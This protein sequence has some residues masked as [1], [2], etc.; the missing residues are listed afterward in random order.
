MKIY[1]IEKLTLV[2][3]DAHCSC[4]LF[5]G[6]CNFC[7]PFCQNSAL[8][9]DQLPDPIDENE[10]E[11]YLKARTN[12]LYGVVISGGEPTINKGLP[13]YIRHIKS[14]YGYKI[15]LD[16][17]GSNP[18]M[19]KQLV[20]EGLVDYVAMDI[21]NSLDDY[22]LAIGIE[23]YDTTK[24]KESID[25]LK[26]GHVDYEFRT[27]LVYELHSKKNIEE[28]AELLNG[29]KRYFLQHFEDRG[30]NICDS[31]TAIP[32]EQAEEFVDILK[33]NIENV[34]LRGY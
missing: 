34:Y 14:A 13:D 7:C 23:N 21:K 16:T 27:T 11:E 20:K 26:E 19:L 6:A 29:A 10:I 18:E 33:K 12:V 17:N 28:I 3:F 32:K 22:D 2:D 4:I 31:L 25:Y 24:V 1:G 5:T 9:I 8:V 15:K 30:G